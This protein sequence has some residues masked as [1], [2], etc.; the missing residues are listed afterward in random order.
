MNETLK[1]IFKQ[2]IKELETSVLQLEDKSNI[3]VFIK[4]PKFPRF[5]YKKQGV[6]NICYLKLVRIL[7]GL[8]ALVCLLEAGFVYEMGGVIRSLDEAFF[9]ISFLIEGYPDNLSTQQKKYIRDFYQEEFEDP[10]DTRK[11][12]IPRD[13]VSSQKIHAA[14]AREIKGYHNPSDYQKMLQ[15]VSKVFSG[16]VHS[17]YPHIMENYG[18]NPPRFHFEGLTG[19]PIIKKWEYQLVQTV[20]RAGLVV[21]NV[22]RILNS[23]GEVKK[24]YKLRCWYENATGY[25]FSSET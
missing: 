9:D 22:A 3:P 5:R 16:Y 24:L 15:T 13:R 12:T 17:A 23:R 8:N 11:G 21:A 7:Y 25:N 6:E 20:Y 2:Y 14:A 1:P 18:G 4:D 19:T 10:S